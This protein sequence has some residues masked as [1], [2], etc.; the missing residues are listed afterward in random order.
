M[1]I[2]EEIR[3]DTEK[4]AKKL[5][6]EFWDR[7]FGASLVLCK[8]EHAAEDLVLR[9]FAQVIVKIDQY[10]DKQ[11]FWNWLYT[12]LLNYFRGDLRKMKAEVG[13]DA[14]F[15]EQAIETSDEAMVVERLAEMD[16]A[17]VRRAVSR[18]SPVL[19]EVVMLRYF[20]D[21]TLQEMSQ[22]M[23]VQ[24]GTVKSRLHLARRCLKKSLEKVFN[25]KES[26]S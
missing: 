26:K 5:V 16:A 13:E 20:E 14:D 2:W 4:G 1:E 15:C 8:D 24:M 12:I 3:S 23:N 17:V 25:E 18:L 7:L 11:P 22:L 19:R 9:T 21:K 10:D 6:S